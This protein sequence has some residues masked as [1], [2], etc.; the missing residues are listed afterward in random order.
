MVL[1]LKSIRLQK[2]YA[3][4]FLFNFKHFN[5]LEIHR[6][7]LERAGESLQKHWS[8]NRTKKKTYNHSFIGT[9]QQDDVCK[10]TEITTP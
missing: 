3:N 9:E 5:I 2:T 10:K 7:K 4:V 1:T 6:L 8:I